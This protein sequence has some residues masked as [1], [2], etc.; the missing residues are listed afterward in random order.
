MSGCC[1]YTPGTESLKAE[2]WAEPSTPSLTRRWRDARNPTGVSLPYK[3]QAVREI[4]DIVVVKAPLSRDREVRR[5]YGN[6][7]GTC[8]ALSARGRLLEP[9]PVFGPTIYRVLATRVQ[10][11]EGR[12][13]AARHALRHERRRIS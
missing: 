10:V 3:Q 2:W 1:G 11:D 5:W 4:R 8:V 7:A 9:F 13:Y 12:S 6:G